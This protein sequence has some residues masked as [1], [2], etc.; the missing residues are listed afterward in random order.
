M[1]SRILLI[2]TAAIALTGCQKMSDAAFEERV[3]AY[4]RTHPEVVAESLQILQAKQQLEKSKSAKALLD[5][6]RKALERD[7]RDFVANPNGKITVV[8]F[9]DFRCGYCKVSAPEVV[10]LIKENPDVRFVFK[11]YPIFGGASNLAAQVTMTAKGK[12][13]GLELYQAFMADKAL[14]EAAI[15]RLLAAQGL[16]PVELA[17]AG[18]APDILQ[19]LEDTKRLADTLKIE[20]TPAFIVG[21][22]MIPGADMNALQ[23]AIA[24]ARIGPLKT[25]PKA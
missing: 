16:N 1:S 20:G 17:A 3:H 10:K 23:Q 12:T 14:D 22:I 6:H 4:L 24:E 5:T 18:K 13:R 7:P 2:L 21:D 9:Y 19:H 8:E 25:P 15:S 11:N